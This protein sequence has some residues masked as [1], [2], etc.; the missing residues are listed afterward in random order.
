MLTSADIR[1]GFIDYFA[2]KHGHTFAPSSPVVPHDD[3]TLL[4]TNAGM[5]QFKPIFLGQVDPS[6]DL[7]SLTRAVNS[8]KCIRAGGK[9]NDLDDVG[10]DFYHHTFFEMLGNWSFGDYFKKEAID[11]AW[12]LLTNVWGVNA[13]QLYATYFAGDSSLGLEPDEESR[14]LWL[15]RLPPERVLPGSTKDNFWEM[16]ET[17][18]CG[19]CSEIHIDSRPGAERA[20]S[21]GRDLVN[22]DHEDV[23]ELWNLVFIQFNRAA[24]G[25]RPLPAK[26]VD[27]GMGLERITRVI[28]GKRSNYDT[29]LFT[30]IF[31][32]IQEVTGADAYTGELEKPADIAYRVIADHIRTLVFA[33]TDG[34]DPS[35]EGRGYVLRRILRRAVRHGRQTLGAQGPFLCDL[36]PT[37][38]DMMGGFFP[39]LNKN[40]QRVTDV[41]REEEEAFGRTL[42]QGIKHFWSSITK[43]PMR[44]RQHGRVTK[45]SITHW[46][47][48]SILSVMDMLSDPRTPEQIREQQTVNVSDEES[49]HVVR[50]DMAELTPELMRS[51]FGSDAIIAAEDAFKLHDTY[52]FPIDLTQI[53]AEERGLTVDVA[54][55]ERLMEEARQ[56]SRA[57]GGAGAVTDTSAALTTDAVASLQ[58]LHVKPTDDSAKYNA[59]LRTTGAT[60]RAIW[61]GTDFDENAESM[62]VRPTDRIAVILDKTSFYAQAGGQ[63]GD[64]GRLVVTKETRTSVHDTHEG[65][66][67]VVEDTRATAGYVLHIGHVRRGEIRVGDRVEC[68]LDKPRRRRV[69]ANHTGTHLLNFALR[70]TLGDHIDQKGS[71]VAPDRLRF[72]F[73][74]GASVKPAEAEQ[75]ER[76]V[77]ERIAQDLV[78]HAHNAPLAKARAVEG[79]RAVFGETYP[80]PV[81][82]V[83]V[84]APVEDLLAAPSDKR[85]RGVSIEFCGGTHV[86]TTGAIEAFTVVGEEPVAKGVRRL[87]CLT[88]QAAQ[89]A[90]DAGFA[91][92]RRAESAGGLDTANLEAELRELSYVLKTASAPMTGAAAVR[93]AIEALQEKLKS[94]R[95][96]AAST[97]REGAVHAARAIAAEHKESVIVA[98]IPAG[99]D[100]RAL[101]AAM[102]AIRATRAAAAVM[103]FSIDE[104]EGKIAIAAHVPAPMIEAGFMAGEWVRAA[105]L[106]CGGKGGGRADSAQGG[107]TDP[108]KLDAAMDTARA[109]AGEKIGV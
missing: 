19:P 63:V 98:Q 83:S 87:V 16:G 21:P 73:S 38:V 10:K 91:L 108:A 107:G 14:E 46:P 4:F 37:V 23:I 65:G 67:F 17:G 7:A 24:D 51:L 105:A 15:T 57:G 33:I 75:I 97:G 31:A 44:Q 99:G 74:H 8:Q 85:W 12:D 109:F 81:R 86:A 95:K 72:D 49:A 79:V 2:Q 13:D 106:A 9:H 29:D 59:A 70:E 52:G 84:G 80:D 71:L 103:L 96:A 39:E 47:D 53:M 40:P 50:Y 11:W 27:T 56:R 45:C 54:G 20:A 61:N 3:P 43:L 100:R 18:P 5:N 68:R 101:L 35:N 62:E 25:L 6:S 22:A 88:G 28:Q 64:A 26:H 58:K 30:P 66:E 102:D 36:A 69:M 1:Q 48:R 90:I 92:R 55:F 94:A 82:V 77:R 42:D 60:V 89:E 41:L 93:G 78:V 32:K 104:D 76:I 34:A